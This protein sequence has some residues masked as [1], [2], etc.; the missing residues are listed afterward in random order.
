[1]HRPG[2]VSS[3]FFGS[4]YRYQGSPRQ[5]S[6]TNGPKERG[7]VPPLTCQGMLV[8]PTSKTLILTVPQLYRFLARRTDSKFN[9][10]SQ[11]L[12]DAMLGR[13]CIIRAIG[14]SPPTFPLKS[15]SPSDFAVENRQRDICNSRPHLQD[16]RIG[17]NC[18]R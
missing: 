1:M 4:G 11:L 9:K 17:W 8:L 15:Q 7:S 3:R 14:N 12:L 16:H 2:V 18:Y 5:E 10:V 13:S 6:P